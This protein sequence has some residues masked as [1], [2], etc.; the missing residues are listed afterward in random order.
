MD[1]YSFY[2][3]SKKSFLISKIRTNLLLITSKEVSN[4]YKNS[5]TKI[6]SIDSI[7]L[8]NKYNDIEINIT[9]PIERSIIKRETKLIKKENNKLFEKNLEYSYNKIKNNRKYPLNPEYINSNKSKSNIIIPEINLEKKFILISSPLNINEKYGNE[10]HHFNK[11]NISSKKLKIFEEEENNSNNNIKNI[12]TNNNIN[13]IKEDSLPTNRNSDNYKQKIIKNSMDYLR[14]V[15]DNLCDFVLRKK[16]KK[17]KNNKNKNQSSNNVIFFN[18][19]LNNLNN[20]FKM[21]EQIKKENIEKIE[22]QNEIIQENKIL[23]SYRKCMSIIKDKNINKKNNKITKNNNLNEEKNNRKGIKNKRNSLIHLNT[24]N[25]CIKNH[26]NNST[27]NEEEKSETITIN[28]SI[29]I[30]NSSN[31]YGVKIIN[32]KKM[33]VKDLIITP[34]SIL[35]N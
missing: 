13:V 30:G 11:I 34:I 35:K 9:H 17:L 24:L 25:L 33:E 29:V 12:K 10:Y 1:S 3:N 14:N 22:K 28:N 5:K 16:V 2:N 21:N 6:N 8:Y 7:S 20:H 18:N 32:N 15:S 23:K 27:D 26:S 19:N 4:C 31:Y